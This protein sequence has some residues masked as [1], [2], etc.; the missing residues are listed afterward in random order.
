[1]IL[2]RKF[3]ELKTEEYAERYEALG[4]L[5]LETD[6]RRDWE[7]QD[8]YLTNLDKLRKANPSVA[9][10]HPN[11]TG[12]QIL[13]CIC[14][15]NEEISAFVRHGSQQNPTEALPL[16]PE[17][18]ND[19]YNSD[20]GRAVS[21]HWVSVFSRT[22]SLCKQYEVSSL[23]SGADTLDIYDSLQLKNAQDTAVGALGRRMCFV[24]GVEVPQE[25]TD[26]RSHIMPSVTYVGDEFMRTNYY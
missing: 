18:V 13:S 14:L 9:R 11:T 23:G 22:I 1:M 10:L 26:L 21:K 15:N 16:V 24:A 25:I 5:V 8:T 6:R 17:E 19:L 20:K 7:F 3:R 4:E 12:S 2:R